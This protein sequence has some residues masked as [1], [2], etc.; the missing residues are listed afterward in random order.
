MKAKLF[1]LAVAI[2]SAPLQAIP[3]RLEKFSGLPFNPQGQFS[4]DVG[5]DFGIYEGFDLSGNLV[6]CVFRV[7]QF[8]ACLEIAGWTEPYSGEHDFVRIENQGPHSWETASQAWESWKT[9]WVDGRKFT[10][11]PDGGSTLILLGL[12]MIPL[13]CVAIR[14]RN[15]F[16]AKGG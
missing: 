4:I 15:R 5:S 10:S 6:R 9:T 7:D 13:G 16:D 11:I 2:A 8:E 3:E 14:N 1:L 12:T